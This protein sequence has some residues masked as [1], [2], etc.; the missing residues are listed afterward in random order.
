MEPKQLGGERGKRDESRG[1]S[2]G[3]REQ[4]AIDSLE[5]LGGKRSESRGEFLRRRR[6]EI[7]EDLNLIFIRGSADYS[8][9]SDGTV[10]HDK[11]AEI[12]EGRSGRVNSLEGVLKKIYEEAKELGVEIT[13]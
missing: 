2:L 13:G 7:I 10:K 11:T 8:I 5:Q 1:K 12:G 4:E 3:Q 9:L 6:Q